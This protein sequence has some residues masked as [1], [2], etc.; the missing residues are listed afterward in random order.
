MIDSVAEIKARLR[1]EDVV[2]TYVQ[3][4]KV[5]RNFKGLCPFHNEKTPSFHVSVEKQLA[6]CFGCQK[7]GDLFKFVEE[8]EHCDFKEALERLAERAGVTLPERHASALKGTQISEPQ[9]PRRDVK[10]TLF[11]LHNQ[12]ADFFVEQLWKTDAG[13]KV[14]AYL[15]K[16][17]LNEA[18]IRE[19]RIGFAPQ[20]DHA[21]SQAMLEAGFSK[22]IL[23]QSGLVVARDFGDQQL[24][25]RFT[26]RLM[27]PIFDLQGRVV[28]FGGRVLAKDDQPKYVNSPETPI[29]HKSSVLY[30]LH[31]AKAHIR[32]AQSAVV[33][34]GYM[35]MLASYQAGVKHVV[36][37]SGTA[38]T[39]EQL[40]LIKRFAPKVVFA[41]DADQA[42]QLAMHRAISLGLTSDI[43]MDVLQIPEGKDPADTA[44][45][46]P[47]AW[48]SAVVAAKPFWTV[49]C[50]IT[51]TS[52]TMTTPEGRRTIRETLFPIL[53]QVSHALDR[54]LYLKDLAH[55]LG[56]RIEQL[57]DDFSQYLRQQRRNTPL[58][59]KNT[60]VRE[61][62]V[63]YSAAEYLMGLIFAYP[64][65][66]S[67]CAGVTASHFP[68]ELGAVYQRCQDY[69]GAQQT[70][71]T[72]PVLVLLTPEER[73]LVERLMVY[74]TVRH[75]EASLQHIQKEFTE[76]VQRL[77][78]HGHRERRE[79][80][81]SAMRAAQQS[82]NQEEEAR[83]FTEYTQFLRQERVG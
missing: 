42:G 83:L 30:G 65:G 68:S 79:R 35:D 49:L 11:D 51:C 24:K 2:G 76:V 15:Q 81:L 69:F 4:K 43:S 22:E 17:G 82:G 78:A 27:F 26:L 19:F 67:L 5:G 16:R 63:Q 44:H 53:A 20:G 37:S 34:E 40:Q 45:K 9:P 73:A 50:A 52:D 41:F 7:G 46:N 80:L 21:L 54:D 64:D 12:A 48:R 55:V 36:A 28:A 72:D 39:V 6:Y 38:L 62:S 33:V 60:E 32:T 47:D 71:H 74:A 57:Y 3:L 61:S 59:K 10:K 18:T 13:A 23:L 56:V 25:D 70:L 75:P 66:F 58:S 8:V 29:Y 14:R 1:I 77:I 31:A